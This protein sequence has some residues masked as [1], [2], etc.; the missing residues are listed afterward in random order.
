MKLGGRRQHIYNIL[1]P[2]S[3]DMQEAGTL[4]NAKCSVPDS[5]MFTK[6]EVHG[7]LI[8]ILLYLLNFVMPS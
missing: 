2:V 1:V 3:R 6:H 4:Q 8:Q 5:L 7:G